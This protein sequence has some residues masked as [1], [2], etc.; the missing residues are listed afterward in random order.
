VSQKNQ[1]LNLS[2]KKKNKRKTSNTK[3]NNNNN[4]KKPTKKEDSES[5]SDSDKK[6]KKSEESDVEV[7]PEKNGEEEGEDDGETHTEIFIKNLPWSITDDSLAEYFGQFGAVESVKVVKK[8]G[9]PNGIGFVKFEERAAGKKAIANPGDMEGRTL[10]CTFS[11]EKPQGNNSGNGFRNGNAGGNRNSG[12]N[13]T[14]FVGNLSFKSTEQTIKKFF[15]GAGNVVSVRIATD[16]NTGRMKGF[17]HVDFDSQ[18]AVQ[19]AIGLAGQN[20][21]GREIR[22]DASEPRKSRDGNGGGFG[23]NRGGFGG[24]RG[25]NRGGFGGRG[26]NRG[27][28]GKPQHGRMGEGMG[29]KTTFDDDD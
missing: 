18:E 23:G 2:L 24:N 19:S 28:F 15:A 6:G 22:V 1:I 5:E 16:A 7:K 10:T 8:D 27:G 4:N 3:A 9:R 12:S 11:N 20:L 25:G 29:K 14:V 21:D 17:A 13:H 26:G